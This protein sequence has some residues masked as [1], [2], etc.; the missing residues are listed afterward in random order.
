MIRK[1]VL[2]LA[3]FFTS[4]FL[5]QQIDTTVDRST[6]GVWNLES[7]V[8]S[9]PPGCLS[10]LPVSRIYAFRARWPVSRMYSLYQ[11]EKKMRRNARRP[12]PENCCNAVP[13]SLLTAGQHYVV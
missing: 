3:F 8:A 6:A 1:G 9:P 7:R 11:R 4:L 10:P 13:F 2:I 12:R 5:P